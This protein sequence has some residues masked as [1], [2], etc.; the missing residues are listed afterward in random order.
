MS[1]RDVIQQQPIGA[2]GAVV[3]MLGVAAWFAFGGSKR[4]VN[5]LATYRWFYDMQIGELVGH[6]SAVG[7]MPP[8]TLENGHEAVG[9]HVYSCEAC[10]PNTPYKIG[11]IEKY[12]TEGNQTT[13]STR[14]EEIGF[15]DEVP[16]QAVGAAALSGHLVAIPAEKVEWVSFA[17]QRGKQIVHGARQRTCPNGS[18]VEC[19]PGQM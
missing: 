18:A 2:Y 3:V 6:P 9:A 11:Y 19:F 5:E 10:G 16:N 17:S 8:I 15:R 4:E 7:T 1:I 12:T 13:D 14:D